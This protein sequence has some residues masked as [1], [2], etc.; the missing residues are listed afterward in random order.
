MSDPKQIALLEAKLLHAVLKDPF[1]AENVDRLQKTLEVLKRPL[2]GV[3]SCVAFLTAFHQAKTANFTPQ[4]G[5]FLHFLLHP[6]HFPAG[7][8]LRL[9]TVPLQ[10]FLAARQCQKGP[11]MAT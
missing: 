6:S 1:D 2:A 11:A 3:F 4:L 5:P 10:L 8:W 7:F 9:P